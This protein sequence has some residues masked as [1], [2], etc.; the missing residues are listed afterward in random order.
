MDPCHALL[1]PKQNLGGE[2]ASD[3]NTP[4]AKYLYPSTFKKSLYLGFDVFI[5]IWSMVSTIGIILL[6]DSFWNRILPPMNLNM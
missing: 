3:R 2:G 1:Y 6:S 4:A 5:D